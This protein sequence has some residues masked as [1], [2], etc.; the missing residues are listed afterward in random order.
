MDAEAKATLKLLVA[1]ELQ[2]IADAHREGMIGW[3]EEIIVRKTLMEH[4]TMTSIVTAD[5]GGNGERM[6]LRQW[7]TRVTKTKGLL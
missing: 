5:S 1:H 4:E 3:D 2:N 6:T 7:K